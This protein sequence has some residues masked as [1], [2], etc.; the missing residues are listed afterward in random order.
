LSAGKSCKP[1]GLYRIAKI[2]QGYLCL[3]IKQ[4]QNKQYHHVKIVSKFNGKIVISNKQIHFCSL[5]CL[6]TDKSLKGGGVQ[7]LLRTQTSHFGEM[8][9]SCK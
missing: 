6:A 5:F 4:K 9:W 3:I 7:L 2:A 1:K 8:I